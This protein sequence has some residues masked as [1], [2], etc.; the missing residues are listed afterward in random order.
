METIRDEKRALLLR[1]ESLILLEL[2]AVR[3]L[4]GEP[5]PQ[6]RVEM[7]PHADGT[8]KA[9]IIHD[10]V[11]E[12]PAAVQQGIV[13]G[14]S[15]TEPFPG[16]AVTIVKEAPAKEA[17]R[18]GTRPTGAGAGQAVAGPAKVKGVG[19]LA[20]AVRSVIPDLVQPFT[21]AQVSTA[22]LGAH[23]EQ[24]KKQCRN[25]S[26]GTTM[27]RLAE[28]GELVRERTEGRSVVYR[29]TVEAAAVAAAPS[30]ARKTYEEIRAGIP[31]ASRS[32]E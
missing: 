14:L 19:S 11:P 27:I 24:F 6:G 29:R 5:L 31:E 2:T 9:L 30:Q 17:P 4:L 25:G 1:V 21:V 3:N 10:E 20:A 23:G 7:V 26:V 32:E 8:V 13:F 22:V 12:P 28:E 18:E 16:K 15:S